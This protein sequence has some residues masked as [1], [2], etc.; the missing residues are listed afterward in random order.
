MPCNLPPLLLKSI[1]T[2]RRK[3]YTKGM[4]S[5]RQISIQS[6]SQPH[7]R[8]AVKIPPVLRLRRLSATSFSIPH[9][10]IGELSAFE[11]FNH[12]LWLAAEIEC[13]LQDAA[14]LFGWYGAQVPRAPL[15]HKV[16]WRALLKRGGRASFPLCWVEL[17]SAHLSKASRRQGSTSD[18]GSIASKVSPFSSGS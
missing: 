13:C 4:A 12:E 7:G 1:I 6:A 16:F 10:S 18:L 17:G 15:N 11:G 3:R 5:P 2:R 8:T 9:V 14:C